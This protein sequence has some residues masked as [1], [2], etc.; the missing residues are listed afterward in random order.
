MNWKYY[1]PNFEYEETLIDSDLP[2]YGH[3]F[4]AYDLVQNVKPEKVVELGTFRGTSFFAFCQAAKDAGL[5]TQL[6]AIDLW[7][8]DK[9]SGYYDSEILKQ[10]KT[11]S[12]KYYKDQKIDLIRKSFNDAVNDFEDSSIDILHIDGLHTKEAVTEDYKNWMPKMKKDGIILFHDIVVTKDDF[13]VYKFWEEIIEEKETIEFY[14]SYGLGVLFVDKNN[15]KEQ[16]REMLRNYSFLNKVKEVENI[17][18]ARK[19]VK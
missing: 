6:H 8:G 9:H 14:Y 4:F 17:R 7:E 11:I 1:E 5:D 2:W 10:V 12:A 18:A 13:G 15:Y 19:G 16:S 3:K